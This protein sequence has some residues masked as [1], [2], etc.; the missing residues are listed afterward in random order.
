[1]FSTILSAWL[2]QKFKYLQIQAWRPWPS[3]VG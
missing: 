1:M 2:E 3:K